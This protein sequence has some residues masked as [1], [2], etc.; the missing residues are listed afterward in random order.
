MQATN[1]ILN[2]G[3][4]IESNNGYFRA[5]MQQDGNFVVYESNRPLWASHTVGKGQYL[6]FQND[7]NLVIYHNGGPT[8]ASNTQHRGKRLVM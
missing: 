1:D 8:W 2:K 7:G 5:T 3:Y 4:Q 6:V